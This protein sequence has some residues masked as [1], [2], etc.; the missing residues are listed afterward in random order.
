LKAVE[1]MRQ[2]LADIEA[3]IRELSQE[4]VAVPVLRLLCVMVGRYSDAE[5]AEH[6]RMLHEYNEMKDLGQDLLGRLGAWLSVC[7]IIIIIWTA[8]CE[9]TL[10]RTLYPRFDLSL[11]D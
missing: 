6:I 2:E 1:K 8:I 11:D 7:H 9:E 3:Q 4:C 10:T 5:L